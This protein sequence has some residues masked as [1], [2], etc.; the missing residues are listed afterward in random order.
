MG[1][2][3]AEVFRLLKPLGMVHLACDPFAKPETLAELGVRQVDL[4]TLQRES[5]F[6]SVS[7]P[8]SPS[9]RGMIGEQELAWMK[10]AAFFINTSQGP[11]VDQKA[12]YRVLK[13]RRIRAA[14]LDVVEVEPI[15]PRR[16]IAGDR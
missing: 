16:P 4:E 14:G 9:T 1:N 10:P 2:I 6:V 5:D 15:P 13:Q 12:L 3:G 8:L 11:I 7:C